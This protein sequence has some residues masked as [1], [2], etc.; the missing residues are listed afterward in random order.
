[1]KNPKNLTDL[2]EGGYAS[3]AKLPE[4]NSI[5]LEQIGSLDAYTVPLVSHDYG[6]KTPVMWNSLYEKLGLNIRNIMLV[7]D[8]QRADKILNALKSD[9]RYLGGGFGVGWKEK[10]EFIDEVRPKD[11]SSVNIIVN[12]NGRL[13]GY[14]TDSEGFVKSLEEKLDSLGKHI[15]N[16]NFIILGAG[17]VAKEVARLIARKEAHRIAV[18]N[19]TYSKAVSIAH[20]LN[21]EYGQISVAGGEDIIRGYS[22]NSFE[23][24][25]AIINLTDKGSD[26]P[27]REYAAFASAELNCDKN[28]GNNINQSRTILRELARLN[29]KVI[30]AD[31]V[32]PRDPPSKTL[33]LAENEG[34]KNILDG[35][36][37]VVYQ[38]VP[39]Y[40][41]IQDAYP[42][43]HKIKAEE[44]E[45]LK[46]FK[47]AAKNEESTKNINQRAMLL[48]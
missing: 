4:K 19:R 42:D 33:A 3:I 48:K 35:I 17:G 45:I 12:E 11:I 22:L 44:K 16:G 21:E 2:L 30:I 25:D 27:L 39:A 29:P 9:P 47:S 5:S 41:K 13:I 46:T 38:A 1:M 31:I 34:L 14:N 18:L 40:L 7:A 8:P 32:L 15:K 37:M 43:K 6:A 26:G 20:E 23:V 24:P 28:A 10:M 36:G